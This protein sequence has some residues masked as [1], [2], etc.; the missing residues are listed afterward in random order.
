MQEEDQAS[1]AASAETRTAAQAY[2]QYVT[3]SP[4]SMDQVSMQL[5]Q[6]WEQSRGTLQL[7]ELVRDGMFLESTFACVAIVDSKGQ[8]RT[9]IRPAACAQALAATDLL[10]YHRDNNASALRIG[11]PP[12]PVG[13][14][15]CSNFRAI[16]IVLA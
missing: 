14:T 11:G 8:L 9:A 12:G 15:F 5:K 3:R 16:W 2:E 13:A 1:A 10:A 7:S 4:A 6:S